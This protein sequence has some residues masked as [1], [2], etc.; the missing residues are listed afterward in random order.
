M[1]STRA[2]A[3][4]P[5]LI[6]RETIAEN[7]YESWR[8]WPVNWSAIAVGA[9]AALAAAVLF[10]LIALAVGAHV[11]DPQY[12]VVDVKTLRIETL[13]FAVCSAFFSFV[14]GGWVAGKIAGILHSEPAMLH[15]AIVWL[16]TVPMFVVLAAIGTG[17]YAGTWYAG[18]ARPSLDR[19][20][21]SATNAVER[22]NVPNNDAHFELG[23]KPRNWREDTARA[24][25]NS[26][27]FAVTSLL[28]GLVGSVVGG[29]MA[30]GEPMNF[31]HHR[32]RPTF[33]AR[34]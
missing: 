17:G 9:L 12:R 26:A 24:T 32:H 2:D 34:T 20:E 8:H 3:L 15:G 21:M 19:S 7:Q 18:L 11:L 6:R 23:N 31:T 5:E 1:V 28:L 4:T 13:A 14:I 16:V 33:G 30:S 22:D 10:S 27:L 29:W 25:R